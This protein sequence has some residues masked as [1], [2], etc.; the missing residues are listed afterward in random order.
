MIADVRLK[1]KWR[2]QV[3]IDTQAVR[4]IKDNRLKV[5]HEEWAATPAE[6]EAVRNDYR[7]GILKEF[8]GC[9]IIF[10][11]TTIAVHLPD[12][13]PKSSIPVVANMPVALCR[14]IHLHRNE[15]P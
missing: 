4:T 3:A 7:Q 1:V 13:Y 14:A 11:W 8:P 5:G 6:V 2:L 9:S 12:G 15:S 10:G